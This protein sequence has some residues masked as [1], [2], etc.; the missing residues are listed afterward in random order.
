MYQEISLPPSLLHCLFCPH[1]NQ[2]TFALLLL[3]LLPPV[4]S[5]RR[6][7]FFLLCDD[8]RASTAM[9]GWRSRLQSVVR[10]GESN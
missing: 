2:K 3:L 8:D 4:D 1:L 6:L 10:G 9:R 7:L 5:R